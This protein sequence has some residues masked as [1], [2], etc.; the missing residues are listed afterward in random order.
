LQLNQVAS[1]QSNI[2]RIHTAQPM[3]QSLVEQDLRYSINDG[4]DEVARRGI[5]LAGTIVKGIDDIL[6]VTR[7]AMTFVQTD[8]YN[9]DVLAIDPAGAQ[10]LDLL[11][12]PG[13]EKFYLWGP[14]RA[15][16]TGPFGRTP[17]YGSRPAPPSSTPTPTAAC[18]SARSS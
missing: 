8:G 16:P 4:L 18:T 13:T 15:T 3:F 7:K 6:E 5:A 12:T 2:P 17:G 9:P 10:A 1:I 14:G 11:R